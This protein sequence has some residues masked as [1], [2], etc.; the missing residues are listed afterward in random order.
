[1]TKHFNF[2]HTYKT[3]ECGYNTENYICT[4]SKDNWMLNRQHYRDKPTSTGG[5]QAS[6]KFLE[7][8]SKDKSKFQT[9]AILCRKRAH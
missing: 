5:E 6:H 2:K 8:W 9:P 3:E 4:H 7:G 1:M